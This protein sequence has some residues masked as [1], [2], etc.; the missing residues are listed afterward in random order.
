M[1]EYKPN[2]Y[3]PALCNKCK[4]YEA[5]FDLPDIWCAP[6]WI[7][8]WIEGIGPLSEEQEEK[9]R[10]FTYLVMA[11]TDL[12]EDAKLSDKLDYIE[13]LSHG[14]ISLEKCRQSID[15]IEDDVILS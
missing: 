5:E 4:K 2:K 13:K 9:E 3:K 14:T 10:I 6:C 8:W 15:K 7:N 11:E 1:N 12:E